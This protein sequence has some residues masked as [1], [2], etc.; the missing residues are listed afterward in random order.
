MI[1]GSFFFFFFYRFFVFLFQGEFHWCGASLAA[2]AGGVRR[3][4]W[5]SVCLCKLH[6]PQ[7]TFCIAR[8]SSAAVI[9]LFFPLFGKECQVD[10]LFLFFFHSFVL[11]CSPWPGPG[12]DP[13]LINAYIR[14]E[15]QS[16][17]WDF[18]PA[19]GT[20]GITLAPALVAYDACLLREVVVDTRPAAAGAWTV[21]VAARLHSGTGLAPHQP[22]PTLS[23]TIAGH[24][25]QTTVASVPAGETVVN[26]VITIPASADLQLWWPNGYGFF[27]KNEN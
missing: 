8:G 27:K 18:A 16:F 10:N 11:S 6:L 4:V 20:C 26:V 23:A 3:T 25:A 19:T 5:A 17:S 24:T 13:L 14:K 22:A 12:P 2:G 9:P 1:T 7:V 21:S 15:Q